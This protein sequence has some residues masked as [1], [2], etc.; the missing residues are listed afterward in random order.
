MENAWSDNIPIW[1]NPRYYDDLYHSDCDCIDDY[2]L[3][4]PV[5]H[6]KA[7]AKVGIRWDAAFILVEHAI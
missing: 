7:L 2:G 6:D 3:V 4:V 1:H 5:Q